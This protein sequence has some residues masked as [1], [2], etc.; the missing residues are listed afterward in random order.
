MLFDHLKCSFLFLIILIEI[1]NAFEI[2][3]KIANGIT[4]GE[5]QFK[6]YVLL[7]NYG[8]WGEFEIC[9]GTLINNYWILT[10][11][12]CVDMKEY[13]IDMRAIAGTWNFHNYTEEGR[14]NIPIYSKDIFIYEKFNRR[15]PLNDIALL[16]TRWPFN[17]NEFVQSAYFP[18]DYESFSNVTVI[19]NGIIKNPM[20]S[21]SEFPIKL[22]WTTMKTVSIDECRKSFPFISRRTIICAIDEN[23]S[24]M[25][26]GDSGGPVICTRTK[27]L[28]G[29][30]SFS[31]TNDGHPEVFTNVQPYRKWITQKTGITFPYC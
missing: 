19:G 6:Y 8:R 4:S 12:H 10:A 25:T 18:C 31:H 29:I 9:G 24:S 28:I 30:S 14:Q 7:I 20:T 3:S 5:N 11:A 1:N 27:K 15:S 21:I 2:K 26:G 23:G 16:R 17:F 13:N 22:Q